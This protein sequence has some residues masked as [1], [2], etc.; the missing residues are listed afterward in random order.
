MVNH[1]KIITTKDNAPS[2]M[3]N[4]R[5]S[6]VSRIKP[7]NGAVIIPPSGANIST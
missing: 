6:S 2:M 4:Q 1:Q 5:Q 7:D 3:N